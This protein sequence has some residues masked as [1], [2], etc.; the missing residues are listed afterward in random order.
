MIP[1][2]LIIEGLYS[3][4]EPQ[5]ID[6][7][8]LTEAG[9]FGI[10]GSVG[11]GKSSILEAISYVLYGETERLNARDKRTYN[12]MNLK[13][14]RSYI[15][16]EFLNH[17]NKKYKATRE[18][19]R[20]SKNFED[21]KTPISGLYEWKNEDW[22]PLESTNVEPIIGLSYENFKRT[23]I[24][25]QGQFKEFLE[26]GEKDR[27]QMM[28]EIF[29]LHQ[30][31]LQ[32]KVGFL[33][34]ENKL[35]LEHLSGQLSGFESI[36]EEK[37][38]QQ[39]EQLVE[40]EKLFTQSK[41]DFD[42]FSEQFQQLKNLKTDF[43]LL[44]KKRL[45]WERI[46][47]EKEEIE[48]LDSKAKTYEKTHQLFY[49]LLQQLGQNEKEL[50]GKKTEV[51]QQSEILSKTQSEFQLIQENLVEIKPKY[52]Q[53]DHF[54][55]IASDLQIV[56]KVLE[57]THQVQELKARTEKGLG[58]VKDLE[59]TNE[60]YQN[61][62]QN[63]E[64]QIE[65]ISKNICDDAV[66]MEIGEWFQQQKSLLTDQIRIQKNQTE[67]QEKIQAIEKELTEQGI[68]SELFYLQS[69][70]ALVLWEERRHELDNQR[71]HLALQEKLSEFSEQLK[72]GEPCPLCGALDHPNI[73]QIENV[74]EE[75]KNVL[76]EIEKSKEYYENWR[77]T[78]E[79]FD[80]DN[81]KKQLFLQ[82][83]DRANEEFNLIGIQLETHLNMFNWKDFNASNS[84]EFETIRNQQIQK[85][86]S[87]KEFQAQQKEIRSK[88]EENRVN[89]EKYKATLEG[90]KRDE[91]NKEAEIKAL[92]SQINQLDFNA[93]KNFNAPEIQQKL[94]DLHKEIAETETRYLHL[95]DQFQTLSPAVASHQTLLNSL[96]S[97]AK[98]IENLITKNQNEIQVH[99]VNSGLNT[100]ENV[101]FILAEN[102]DLEAIRSRIQNYLI[103]RETLQNSIQELELKLKGKE[104]NEVIYETEQQ[105]FHEVEAQLIFAT[106]K[107]AEFKQEIN[108]L[109]KE[110][111]AKA[112]LLKEQAKL[113]K[114]EENLRTMT[115]LF[116]GAGFVQYVSSIYLRQ[117]CDNANVRFHR[118]TRNQLSLQLSEKGDFEIIDYLNEGRSRSVKTL[119]G[120]QSFQASLSLALA[121]A[122]SVQ[123][124]AQSEKNFFFID[125]GFGTQDNESVNIVFETLSSLQKENR[126]VGIISH[127]EE[128][129]ER[130]PMALSITKDDEK[131]SLINYV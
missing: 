94:T 37:I 36:S 92:L 124:Q 101:Q 47:A 49:N 99:L 60:F 41:K 62:I 13:S 20:N 81:N 63:L 24:I 77:K 27:T 88:S 4:Q 104:W 7:T 105:K 69:D 127:V 116:K 14:N 111:A 84:Q 32:D 59:T 68:Q 50:L 48:K 46:S 106:E 29:N 93:Y 64:N 43:E 83:L 102:L 122:E 115:N 107:V 76:V 100:I 6:F 55:Q 30:Y 10:F 33:S 38:N 58:M 72:E 82:E 54:K 119:S 18:F 91:S 112:N 131:G 85:N 95:Q 117:L 90:F 75:L 121:L 126:I 44:A 74:S 118:M 61:Q 109:E 130:I 5:K 28:K 56:L 70:E 79:K 108:R 12:M 52:E 25:P 86:K 98:E 73:A 114:R 96:E 67:N 2:K 120:G 21:V 129:K 22:F 89:L 97:R 35:K 53:L 128:L 16:F 87:I 40:S 11:S 9:L 31:D 42:L 45:D 23:I 110:F 80:Q 123:S 39:K 65:E 71:N 26:L 57:N 103:E 34:K 51:Q 125:E 66:L 15:E 19:R 78:R 8:K 3:Y 17:E 1:L 113:Q